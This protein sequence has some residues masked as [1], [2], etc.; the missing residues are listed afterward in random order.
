MSSP[1]RLS[2]NL[3]KLALI[4]NSSGH[5][6]PDIRKFAK[7][8][9]NCGAAGVTIHPRQDQRHA[10]YQDIS[11]LKSVVG[12]VTGS[13][14]NVVGYPTETLLAHI[15]DHK[16]HQFTLVPDTPDQITSDHGWNLIRHASLVT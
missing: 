6:V 7:Q 12:S 3:N 15:L 4:R 10:T 9:L 16:P 14:L 5:D 8:A 11:D 13:E 1:T 2:V